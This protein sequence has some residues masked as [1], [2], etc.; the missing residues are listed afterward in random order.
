LAGVAIITEACP[1]PHRTAS[2]NATRRPPIRVT[3]TPP[4]DISTTTER[5]RHVLRTA[6]NEASSSRCRSGML[7]RGI[8]GRGLWGEL[9]TGIRRVGCG[10]IRIDA[11]RRGIVRHEAKT[12]LT[13][14]S[15]SADHRRHIRSVGLFPSW[16]E[17]RSELDEVGP[18]P[19]ADPSYRGEPPYFKS[20]SDA[21]PRRL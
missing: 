19:H 9:R 14:S 18:G 1:L 11:D 8:R 13:P 6:S 4:D 20:S 2:P 7:R 3:N 10:G 16:W 17:L 12:L 15:C 21:P 5:P